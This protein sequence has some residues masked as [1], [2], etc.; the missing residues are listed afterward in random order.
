[1]HAPTVAMSR[2]CHI[3]KSFWCLFAPCVVVLVAA[4]GTVDDPASQSQKREVVRQ[5]D[6]LMRKQDAF[7]Q[8]A[9]DLIVEVEPLRSTSGWAGVV[10]TIHAA[11]ANPSTS[12]FGL[13]TRQ[14]ELTGDETYI[15]ARRLLEQSAT[16]EQE[17]QR[18]LGEW[19]AAMVDA[20][21]AISTAQYNPRQL[22]AVVGN[23][24]LF[25]EMNKTA[26]N[27]LKL[28]DSGFLTLATVQRAEDA[29][30]PMVGGRNR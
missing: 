11:R 8:R 13:L 30:L 19:T 27:R 26:L 16:L 12:A 1:L 28:D 23:T 22:Q 14:W 24:E 29:G 20:R 5:T 6:Q 9:R 4:C 10:R 18:L 2:E 17:R 15:R 21:S 7:L 25:Y 3:A